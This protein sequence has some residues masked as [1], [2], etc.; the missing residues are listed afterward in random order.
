[1]I[2]PER[3]IGGLAL[4]DWKCWFWL[5]K[6][7]AHA[8]LNRSNVSFAPFLPEQLIYE[9]TQLSFAIALIQIATSHA[10]SDGKPN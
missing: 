9:P 1:V 4:V 7:R 5:G 6:R 10:P 8:G 2:R 3:A